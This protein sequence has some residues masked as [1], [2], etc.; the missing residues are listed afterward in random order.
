[1][2]QTLRKYKHIV[3]ALYLPIFLISFFLLEKWNPVSLWETSLPIDGKIPFV[4][5]FVLFYISWYPNLILTGF[6]LLLRDSE[7]FKR[8]MWSIMIGFS[9]SLLFYV[10]VPNCQSLR[11]EITDQNIFAKIVMY[12]YQIDTHTNVLP[13]MHVIG[14]TLQVFA[15]FYT[16]T[17]KRA[18]D[19]RHIRH[20]GRADRS[21]HII[22]Q[23]ARGSRRRGGPDRQ[24]D[25]LCDRLCAD[26]KETDE[27]NSREERETARFRL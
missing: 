21:I 15:V 19:P 14:A 9:F 13:S 25:R 17:I 1:M 26:R 20:S 23:A 4:E 10:L 3:W 12:L 11:P 7:G 6:F 2:K 22:Y 16:K 5:Q 18:M 24:R 27:T 8:Y